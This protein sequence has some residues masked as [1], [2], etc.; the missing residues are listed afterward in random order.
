[1]PVENSENPKEKDLIIM[2]NKFGCNIQTIRRFFDNNFLNL[3]EFYKIEYRMIDSYISYL[4]EFQM[5][6]EDSIN[7]LS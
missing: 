6:L 7:K 3:K 5:E 1:M 4:E 2:N